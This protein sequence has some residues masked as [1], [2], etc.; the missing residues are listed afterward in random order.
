[1]LMASPLLR[2]HGFRHAFF[3]RQGGVSTGAYASLNFASSTG[4]DPSNVCENLARAAA[5]LDVRLSKL[6]FA[7]Q[8]HGIDV[9][10]VSS[11]DDRAET[12]R[13]EADAVLSTEPG[14]ACSVRSADCGTVLVGDARSGAVVAAHAGWR[15]T[16]LGVV[17]AAVDALTRSVGEPCELVAAVG[18][19]IEA[20]CFEVG[21]DVAARLGALAPREAVVT[22]PREKAHVDLRAII[23]TKLV[24]K[25]V[26]A[27]RVDHVRGCTMC[28]SERFFSF[29]RD[30]KASGRLLAAIVARA[31]A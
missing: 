29:R 6:H 16:E 14:I 25:G 24:Q 23:G 7:S 9:L 4:D 11:G 3:T 5:A 8:V 28:D 20:C 30:G 19:L 22:R 17:E 12:V 13:R 31:P 10:H 21:D 2:A 15:G 27:T 18:P 26:S 1:M